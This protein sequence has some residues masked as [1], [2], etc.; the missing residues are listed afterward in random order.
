MYKVMRGVTMLA[1]IA[2]IVLVFNPFY[3]QAVCGPQPCVDVKDAEFTF[4]HDPIDHPR[5]PD[6]LEISGYLEQKFDFQFR[7]CGTP[8][9]PKCVDTYTMP[10]WSDRSGNFRHTALPITVT[11][12]AN[13]TDV[14]PPGPYVVFS[15]TIPMD[16]KVSSCSKNFRYK[17]GFLNGDP[18]DIPAANPKALYDLKFQDRT[19]RTYFYIKVDKDFFFTNTLP[20]TKFSLTDFTNVAN[21]CLPDEP[22]PTPPPPFIDPLECGDG[23]CVGSDIAGPTGPSGTHDCSL[24]LNFVRSITSFDITIDID[25][26]AHMWTTTTPV[27]IDRD[28]LTCCGSVNKQELD[29]K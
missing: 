19:D 5:Y 18:G 26:G 1:V 17:G 29:F 16:T 6:R 24:Y 10:C 27:P 25:N 21:V 9:D 13:S 4:I 20:V 28:T 12:T 11:I 14:L 7:D 3:A 8:P 22:N 23:G 15:N 2:A